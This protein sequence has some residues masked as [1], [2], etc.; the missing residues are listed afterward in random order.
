MSEKSNAETGLGAAATGA[1][2]GTAAGRNCCAGGSCDAAGIA[3]EV[4]ALSCIGTS[5]VAT[6]TAAAAGATAISPPA[7]R[8][9]IGSP[10]FHPAGMGGRVR[11]IPAKLTGASAV[12]AFFVSTAPAGGRAGFVVAFFSAE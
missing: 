10:G 6:A 12:G 7:A 1:V 2:T 5:A 3:I 4:G 11:S 8:P 9:G